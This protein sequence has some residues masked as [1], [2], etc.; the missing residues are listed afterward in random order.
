MQNIKPSLKFEM[1]FSIC[2]NEIK[3]AEANIKTTCFEDLS[4][5]STSFFSITDFRL[6]TKRSNFVAYN[7]TH[8]DSLF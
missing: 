6:S 1:A 8:N 5:E 3:P 2:F 7:T 4:N